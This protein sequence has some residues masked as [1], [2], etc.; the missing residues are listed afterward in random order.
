M[1][2]ARCQLL[3]LPPSSPEHYAALSAIIEGAT[4]S[5]GVITFMHEMGI[6]MSL[7]EACRKEVEKYGPG[8][9]QKIRVAVGELAAIDPELLRFAWEATVEGPDGKCALEID[10]KPAIQR[11]LVCQAIKPRPENSWLVVCPD[12]GSP[13]RVEGGDEL[14]LLEI[15]YLS[16][17]DVGEALA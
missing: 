1:P 13:L 17:S 9:L 10:W 5:S 7:Y 8:H 6:A 4:P 3:S 11:C 2:P 15:T 16:D 14:D 12:C